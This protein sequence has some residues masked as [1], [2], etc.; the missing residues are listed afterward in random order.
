M[1]FVST[2]LLVFLTAC[3]KGEQVSYTGSTPA[4][5]TVVRAFLGIPQPDSI[6]FIR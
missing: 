6:D 5:S 3:V 1:K 2:F 4:N